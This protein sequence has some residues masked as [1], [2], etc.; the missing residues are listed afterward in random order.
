MRI[1]QLQIKLF[2]TNVIF[3][4]QMKIKQNKTNILQYKWKLCKQIELFTINNTNY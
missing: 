2:N 3:T 4:I 1:I